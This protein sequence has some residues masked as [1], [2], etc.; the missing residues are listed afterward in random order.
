MEVKSQVD[1]GKRRW[2]LDGASDGTQV[3][4]VWRKRMRSVSEAMAMATKESFLRNVS[5]SFSIVLSD[6]L[7]VYMIHVSLCL[8]FLFLPCSFVFLFH[9]FVKLVLIFKI[10]QFWFWILLIPLSKT[11]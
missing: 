8:S 5:I 9:R 7:I 6:L 3:L 2:G 11:G 10:R 4:G 1:L